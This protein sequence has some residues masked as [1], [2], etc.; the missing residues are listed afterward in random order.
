MAGKQGTSPLLSDSTLPYII[1]HGELMGRE[2]RE[3]RTQIG[4]RR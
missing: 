2:R 3:Q 4:D 1:G